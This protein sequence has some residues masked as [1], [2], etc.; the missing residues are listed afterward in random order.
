[1]SDLCSRF[2]LD[3]MAGY[4]AGIAHDLAKQFDGKQLTKIIKNAGMTISSLEKDKP[5]LLHGRA[6]TVLLRERFCVHN[7]D[8]LEAVACHTSGSENM[9]T[10]AKIIYIAD[11]TENSRRIDPALREMCSAVSEKNSLDDLDEI[12]FAVLE[13]TI[14]KLKA[15]KLVLSEDT[16]NLLNKMT[17]AKI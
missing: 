17:Q 16:L 13:K 15:K 10:L 7:E 6:A 1:A 3:P 14:F 8:I 5:S 12:L 9:G 11:K 4:L 2:G